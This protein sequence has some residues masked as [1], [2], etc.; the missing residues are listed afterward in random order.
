[1]HAEDTPIGWLMAHSD[2]GWRVVG[3][4]CAG[5]APNPLSDPLYPVNV[6]GYR[7]DC[8]VCGRTLAGGAGWPELF[9]RERGHRS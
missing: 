9:T 2:G 7:Q 5:Q 6:R 3:P 1:M 4:C 8:F